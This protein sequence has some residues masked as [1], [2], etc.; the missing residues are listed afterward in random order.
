MLGLTDLGQAETLLA[1]YEGLNGLAQAPL[2]ELAGRYR[3]VGPGKAHQLKAAFELG[4][5]ASSPCP[6][7]GC[8]SSR[9]PTQ[10]TCC[11]PT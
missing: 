10:P 9:P 5:A 3:G 8:A 4:R 11:W 1:R 7:S 6:P 2:A